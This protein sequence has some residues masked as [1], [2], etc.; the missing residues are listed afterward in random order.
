MPEPWIIS[1]KLAPPAPP[2]NWLRRGHAPASWPAL[3]AFT[4]GPGFG[5]TL[6]LCELAEQARLQAGGHAVV[7]G[8]GQLR[9][10]AAEQA[11]L[12]G[13]AAAPGLDGW[14]LGLALLARPG[15]R[16]GDEPTVLT[17]VVADEF[18]RAQRAPR[19]QFMLAAA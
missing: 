2:A 5:K 13:K 10:T 15:A 9:F 16:A 8:E 19:R 18:Y 4:A 1:T 3:W 17:E 12:L 7:I 14:P 11:Q 6:G